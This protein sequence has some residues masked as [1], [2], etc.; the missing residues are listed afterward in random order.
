MS[1]CKYCLRCAPATIAAV[2]A[3]VSAFP[4]DFPDENEIS[5]LMDNS[6]MNDWILMISSFDNM[7][8]R[9]TPVDDDEL[10]TLTCTTEGKITCLSTID[11]ATGNGE[12]TQIHREGWQK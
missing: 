6:E 7:K 11:A 1:A 9:L 2:T 4:G 10:V 3:F 12:V 8:Y 5:K